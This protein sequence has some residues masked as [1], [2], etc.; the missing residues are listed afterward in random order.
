MCVLLAI[1]IVEV[2]ILDKRLGHHMVIPREAIVEHPPSI[3]A[4]EVVLEGRGQVVGIA[5]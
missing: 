5:V 2:G 3:W 1:A 4:G